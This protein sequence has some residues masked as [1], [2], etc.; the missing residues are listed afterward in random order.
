MKRICFVNKGENLHKLQ[1]TI[2]L[3]GD[4]TIAD[5]KIWDNKYIE[6]EKGLDNI[7]I[8]ENYQPYHVEKLSH[9][10]T[11]LD[12][13]S[14]GY[15]V[16]GNESAEINDLV[17]IKKMGGVR[18][19]VKPLEKLEDIANKLGVTKEIIME[20]NNLNNDKLFVGQV[21]LV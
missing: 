5:D 17:V 16:V 12:I 18:Y 6:L 9:E 10:N 19:I 14:K 21:L 2:G 15:E 1:Y 7:V 13:Y 20:N 11:L 4:V 8:V 3:S